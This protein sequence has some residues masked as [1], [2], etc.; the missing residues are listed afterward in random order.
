LE[1]LEQELNLAK[2]SLDE[3]YRSSM[4]NLARD[5]LALIQTYDRLLQQK[6]TRIA[7]LLKDQEQPKP[8]V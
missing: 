8:S 1:S 7:E 2:Q 6:D 4:R 3:Q 5:I